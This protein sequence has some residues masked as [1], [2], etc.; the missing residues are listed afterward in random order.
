MKKL[1]LFGL[2]ISLVSCMSEKKLLEKCQGII[3]PCD[4]SRVETITV[5]KTD[6]IWRVT[7]MSSLPLLDIR[8]FTFT[9]SS[10]LVLNT[11]PIQ[12]IP[13]PTA[14]HDSI[15]TYTTIY[16]KDSLSL[17][18]AQN[19][20]VELQDKLA[21]K[22]KRMNVVAWV[23]GSSIFLLILLLVISAY[24]LKKKIA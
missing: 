2:L 4:S 11:T 9:D 1:L 13:C 12:F 18:V 5:T 10:K 6:T 3:P 23:I 22:S 19:K 16:I 8:C 20:I 21:L 14:I 7:P 24:F 17:K 15:T